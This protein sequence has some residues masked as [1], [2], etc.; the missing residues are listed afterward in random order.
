MNEEIRQHIER[1]ERTISR[2]KMELIADDALLE[3]LIEMMP[4]DKLQKL[5][6]KYDYLEIV[7]M[8]EDTD[9]EKQAIMGK[10]Q[11]WRAIMKDAIR[12]I[13]AQ[14]PSGSTD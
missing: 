8:D 11:F 10:V 3:C 7:S 4:E 9:A 2:I 13:K 1:L 12:K 14:N 6:K 5:L